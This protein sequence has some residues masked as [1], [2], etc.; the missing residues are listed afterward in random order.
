MVVAKSISQFLARSS[1]HTHCYR[2]LSTWSRE[3]ASSSSPRSLSVLSRSFSSDGSSVVNEQDPAVLKS[4]FKERLE[5]E[6][7][8]SLLGGGPDRIDRQHAK[9]SLGQVAPDVDC[10]V[11]AWFQIC[12]RLQR[13]GRFGP[14]YGELR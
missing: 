9:G 3:A 14:L 8:K 12:Y 5:E 7:T 10:S 2:H 11:G 6:R 4:N 1:N 13:H